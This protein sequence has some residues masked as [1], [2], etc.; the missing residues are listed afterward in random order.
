MEIVSV[1]SKKMCQTLRKGSALTFV[2]FKM[3]HG[4]IKNLV[5]WISHYTKFTNE[6]LYLIKGA[7]MN[8][9]YKLTGS[10]AY[11]D[12]LNIVCIDLNDLEDYRP[13]IVPRFNVDGRWLDDVIDNNLRRERNK[14]NNC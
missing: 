2:G 5:D 8:K 11:A 6:R 14:R 9:W 1:T 3:E 13:I 10:N 7:D 12:S 4:N